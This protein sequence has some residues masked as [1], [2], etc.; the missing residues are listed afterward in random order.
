M[1]DFTSTMNTEILLNPATDTTPR[2]LGRGVAYGAVAAW[3]L[4][5]VGWIFFGYFS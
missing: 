5:A 2:L 4:F 3:F 1:V